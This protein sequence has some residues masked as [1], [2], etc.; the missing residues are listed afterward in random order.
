M[1]EKRTKEMI[2][3]RVVVGQMAENTYFV[4]EPVSKRGF[5][6]DPGAEAGRL[7]QIIKDHGWQIEMI[8]LT[9][10]HFDHIGAVEQLHTSLK[11]PY[12]IHQQGC[13]MLLDSAYN[14]SSSYCEQPIFLPDAIYLAD[15]ALI[16][17]LDYFQFADGGKLD[18]RLLH[19]PGHTM[20]SSAFYSA[21][22]GFAFVGDTLFKNGVGI[23]DVPGG[24]AQRLQQ[25][26]DKLFTLPLETKIYPG[27]YDYS[28]L[29]DEVAARSN[30]DK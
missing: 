16:P 2:I 26:L 17:N 8:L 14:L 25:S 15:N 7:L 24:S 9:H 3:Q 1:N 23:T 12:L 10:G 27:H 22:C 6:V 11:I 30:N 5:V 4:V 21:S 18:L 28:Y 13:Q 19:L 20:D 29:K